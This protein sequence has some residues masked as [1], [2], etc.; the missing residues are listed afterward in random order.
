MSKSAPLPE[1][2]EAGSVPSESILSNHG[3][4]WLS[5]GFINDKFSAHCQRAQGREFLR[6]GVRPT[7][8]QR[9]ELT[10]FLTSGQREHKPFRISGEVVNDCVP[11]SRWDGLSVAE[12]DTATYGAGAVGASRLASHNTLGTSWR[13][14][15]STSDCGVNGGSMALAHMVRALI[16][17][18]QPSLFITPEQ[19]ARVWESNFSQ[20]KKEE[21]RKGIVHTLGALH[22]QR[23]VCEG[24]LNFDY[25]MRRGSD[26]GPW[27][28][29]IPFDGRDVWQF[30][31]VADDSMENLWRADPSSFINLGPAH[32]PRCWPWSDGNLLP[33]QRTGTDAPLL[34]PGP[35]G[36][37]S[38]HICIGPHGCSG[39][40]HPHSYQA[41]AA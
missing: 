4:K 38:V 12:E 21:V 13:P 40:D 34:G 3:T 33:Y 20:E 28:D 11:T 9:V 18:E 35:N 26:E 16:M 10:I 5:A 14:S 24:R 25:D 36:A 30:A 37:I 8:G 39:K 31:L 29:G 23:V 22:G 27:I 1:H 7:I 41:Q 15:R 32:R 19:L 2:F 17:R 6:T